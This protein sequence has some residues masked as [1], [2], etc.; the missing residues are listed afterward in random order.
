MSL[1]MSGVSDASLPLALLTWCSA[2]TKTTRFVSPPNDSAKRAA[3]THIVE[4]LAVEFGAAR[5]SPARRVQL[6][7]DA[8]SISP[9]IGVTPVAVPF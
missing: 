1:P 8:L 4:S 5:P 6:N 7:K 9:A 2:G 3:G